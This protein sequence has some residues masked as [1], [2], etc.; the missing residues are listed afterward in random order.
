LISLFL[1]AIQ[2]F[3]FNKIKNMWFLRFKNQITLSIVILLIMPIYLDVF[4]STKFNEAPSVMY[5]MEREGAYIKVLKNKF[6]SVKSYTVLKIV[7]NK[8]EHL[9]QI[10]FY[11]RIYKINSGYDIRIADI[12]DIKKDSIFLT[13]QK[14]FIDT[15]ESVSGYHLI[16]SCEACKLYDLR[17]K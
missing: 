10:K 9:D 3:V 16:D 5:D 6:P 8:K 15:I 7:E 2:E 17:S 11:Q 4:A 14:S 13:C 12:M 1:V